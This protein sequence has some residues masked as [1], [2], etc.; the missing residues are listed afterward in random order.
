MSIGS[1]ASSRRIVRA[2]LEVAL[3]GPVRRA[4]QVQHVVPAPGEL[5]A[6]LDGEGKAGVVVDDDAERHGF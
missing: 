4:V 6:E 3:A 1:I 5:A 2:Q